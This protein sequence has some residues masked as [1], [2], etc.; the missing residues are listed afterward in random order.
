MLLHNLACSGAWDTQHER[1][2]TCCW[3][4]L[5]LVLRMTVTGI[6]PEKKEIH[7]S[8]LFIAELRWRK[9]CQAEPHN[10]GNRT[11]FMHTN[12]NSCISFSMASG[13][14]CGHVHLTMKTKMTTACNMAAIL[15]LIGWP[16]NATLVYSVHL[17]N[18]T[19]MLVQLT[20]V[21]TR[22][23]L[24]SIMWP[25]CGSDFELIEFTCFFKVDRWPCTGFWLDH[26]LEPG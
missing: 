6:L 23:P 7:F 13:T 11:T 3:A 5:Q 22:Y 20:P 8:I 4:E 9:G 12:R 16:R 2:S 15:Q 10:Y 26:R 14:H 25:Y 24:T 19:S 17:W 1:L 18:W 21:K